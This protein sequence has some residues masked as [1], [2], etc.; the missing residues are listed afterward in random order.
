M[1]S[2]RSPK[3]IRA[4]F[5]AFA[6]I[7]AL[8]S[9][10]VFAQ[11]Q[12]QPKTAPEEKQTLP[13]WSAY[14]YGIYYKNLALQDPQSAE[15]SAL[16][17]KSLAHFHEALKSG[18]S[19]GLIYAQIS[20]CHYYLYEFS[21]SLDYARK[22]I[23]LDK[24]EIQPY[25][26]M[27]NIYMRL[28]NNVKAA[29]ILEEYLTND[30]ENIY[31]RNLL[32][33][34]YLNKIRDLEKAA[35][36]FEKVLELS[37]REAVDD[38]YRE[39]ALYGLGFIRYNQGDTAGAIELFRRTIE[40]N[41]NNLNVLYMLAAI[42]MEE[43]MIAEAEKYALQY[44]PNNPENPAV[45]SILG[46]IYYIKNNPVSGSFLLRA[47]ASK[48][49]DG[50]LSRALYD[51]LLGN[52]DA[53]AATLEA[54]LKIRPKMASI[55][56]ALGRISERKNDPDRAFNEYL[57]AGVL[58]YQSGML[59]ESAYYLRRAD[60]IKE[61]VAGINYYL[62]RAYEDSQ[63][64]SLAILHYR[65]A[66]KLNPNIDLLIH[67]GYLYG[68]R[69][70]YDAAF[71]SFSRASG[72]DPANS[73]PYFFSGLVALW[74][75]NYP[76]AESDIRKAISLN[77]EDETYYFYLAMV[78]EKLHKFDEAVSSLEQAIKYNPK[79]AR[80][81]NFLGYLYADRNMKIDESHSLILKAIEIE[82]NNGAYIDSLG[83]VYYRKGN[84]PEAL[85]KLLEAER[86][87][88]E[89]ESSD[90][91]VFDHIG[92]TY[93]KLGDKSRAVQYWKKSVEHESN[94]A[95]E[96]KIRDNSGR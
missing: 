18:E 80:A 63:R 30:P 68:V 64:I 34:H 6:A 3:I 23:E 65:K 52:D 19:L 50:T 83:W 33:E 84:F 95:I 92:D 46:R 89:E 66:E 94:E 56:I 15:S 5:L 47:S 29:E 51:E 85:E 78:M 87:L 67:I 25:N 53:A 14:S 70:Q 82:P 16:L 27:Y 57:T 11:E 76:Q 88:A 32:A 71:D 4:A 60:R 43:G 62:G 26:R 59:T 9:P 77:G 79:S 28:G 58:L 44:F 1:K 35:G 45:N 55:H 7:L 48:S 90:P 42:C 2:N 21:Q 12:A 86:L 72:M 61:N 73:R 37:E 20:E 38:Y 93:L 39:N 40:L 41:R 96:K 74:K 24:K 54:G 69:G 10:G 8:A 75:K 36:C 22:A 49:I 17:K 13:G 81:Y 91:C 31:V